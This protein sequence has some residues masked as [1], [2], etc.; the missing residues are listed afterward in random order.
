MPSSFWLT[1]LL[2]KRISRRFTH[3]STMSRRA[4]GASV[5]AMK[6]AAASR[7][8][9]SVAARRLTYERLPPGYG[10]PAADLALSRDVAAGLEPAPGRMHDYIRARTAFFDR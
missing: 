6:D 3:M 2:T 8:A 10:T 1:H 5:A 4:P 9:R 7:T